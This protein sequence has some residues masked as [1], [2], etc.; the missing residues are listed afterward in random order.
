MRR[1]GVRTVLALA[2]T[3]HYLGQASLAL[4]ATAVPVQSPAID[5][6]AANGVTFRALY[7]NET[8]GNV[9]GGLQQGTAVSH[10]VVAGSDIDLEKAAGWSGTILHA[11]IIAIK[12]HG[13]TRTILAAPSI[14]RKTMRRLTSC[15]LPI[16][17]WRRPW[18]WAPPA[19]CNCRP[20]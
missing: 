11:N 10:Y 8:A 9:S 6:V 12:S 3:Q 20:A 4:A 16:S 2:L 7:V 19:S 5:A 18:R 15:A 13:L 14:P 1:F 17:A